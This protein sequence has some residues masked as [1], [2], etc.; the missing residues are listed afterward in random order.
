[1]SDTVESLDDLKDLGGEGAPELATVTAEPKIDQYGR[2][3]GTGRRKSA[4][5][6]VWQ[7]AH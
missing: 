7:C 6:R 3:Y 2:A 1:M 4:V 5:A